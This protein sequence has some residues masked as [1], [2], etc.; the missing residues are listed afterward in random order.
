M[1]KLPAGY[2][3][4]VEN[5]LRSVE[6]VEGYL[7]DREAKFLALLAACPTSDGDVLE[8]G[9]YRGR[10]ASILSQAGRL[11]GLPKI[12]AIDPLPD[13]EPMAEDDAGERSARALLD[14]NLQRCGVSDDVEVIQDYSY[15]VATA[16]NR[17]LR[18][19]WI[20]GDHSYRGAKTDYDLFIDHLADGGILAMHDVLHLDEGP[21]KVFVEDV[22]ADEHV[23]PAG[24]CGSIGWAQYF[25]DPARAKPFAAHKKSLRRRMQ[26]MI[27]IAACGP[28]PKPL[29][30]LAYAY[31]RWRVPHADIRPQHWISKVA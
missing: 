26:P 3:E 7:T 30:R 14:Q 17:P 1:A 5:I 12:T 28:R 6:N 4:E 18:L 25:A 31:H 10:S 9:S 21:I 8:I 16:W 23:G 22:L 29:S 15:N 13:A 11:T 24:L 20:D 19:L 27:P 2:A